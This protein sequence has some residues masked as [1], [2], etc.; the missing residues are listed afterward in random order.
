M[1]QENV[2]QKVDFSLII[3]LV[4]GIAAGIGVGLLGQ[5]IPVRL[6][7]TFTSVFG[8]LLSF[9]VP[10]IILAFITVGI[11]DLGNRSGKIL[12]ITVALAY[13]SSVIVGLYAF[14]VDS[15][16]FPMFLSQGSV[17]NFGE[18]ASVAPFLRMDIPPIMG[19]TSALVLSFILGIGLSKM[20]GEPLKVGFSN[21]NS[22]VEGFVKKV[23]IPLLPVHIA[24]VFASITYT[25]QAAVVMGAFA[26]V[27]GVIILLHISALVVM[28]LI[29][30][31]I[32]KKN[33]FA[34]L[35][36]MLPSYLTAIGTQSSAATIP[37]TVACIKSN[38]VKGPIAEFVGSLCA[39]IHLSGSTMTLTSCALA[40]MILTG[41]TFTFP[42]MLSFILTL[43][44]I[45]VAAPGIPGGA[46]MAALGILQS[47]LGFSP[48]LN[49]LMIALY[50]AQD[51]F[52]TACNVT[53]D[54]AIALI[55]D[56]FADEK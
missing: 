36:N 8:A 41:H 48:E 13:C 37:V 17:P 56:K 20:A 45:M 22:I 55:V 24:G 47:I 34:C 31:A 40:V 35:R 16:I 21:F 39:T 54:G 2:P 32:S 4:L 23:I 29:A 51:S 46:V 50:L 18:E 30:G 53:G 27:F 26:K 3:R 52:G 11:A 15:A 43:G 28:Y 6:L 25:G 7:A 14:F 42:L 19:V 1:P 49:A 38:G 10:L 33:P 9:T 5:E 12:G 44:V